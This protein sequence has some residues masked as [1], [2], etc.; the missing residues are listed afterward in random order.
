MGLTRA[1]AHGR[2]IE[3]GT[4]AGDACKK[5]TEG[6]P[7][8]DVCQNG[9]QLYDGT[10]A[11]IG[12]GIGCLAKVDKT[13]IKKNRNILANDMNVVYQDKT[14][15]PTKK[16]HPQLITLMGDKESPKP[17]GWLSSQEWGSMDKILLR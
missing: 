16:N 13:A 10:L 2:L 6:T 15:D 17:P 11:A 14:F 5:R 8:K 1:W 7:S 12:W 9:I 4:A 3:A